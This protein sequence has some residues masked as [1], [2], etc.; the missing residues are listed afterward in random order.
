MAFLVYFFLLN[1][2]LNFGRVISGHSV[3]LNAPTLTQFVSPSYRN[4]LLLWI[5][6]PACLTNLPQGNLITVTSA[7]TRE[8]RGSL[9]RAST[10]QRHFVN[11]YNYITPRRIASCIGSWNTK[12]RFLRVKLMSSLS[13]KCLLITAARICQRQV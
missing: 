6:Q 1:Q 7:T 13:V 8:P 11:V 4:S 12:Y 5:T 10:V 3:Y 9:K 2:F